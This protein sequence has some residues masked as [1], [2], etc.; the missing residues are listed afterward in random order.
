VEFLEVK[1]YKK[2]SRLNLILSTDTK[3]KLEFLSK[4]YGMN[5]TSIIEGL[6]N[7]SFNQHKEFNDEPEN[8]KL[9]N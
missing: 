9:S 5:Y 4:Y 8:Q 7:E 2:D 6:I 1:K 3:N